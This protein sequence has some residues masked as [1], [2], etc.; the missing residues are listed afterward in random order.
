MS[1]RGYRTQRR[2][3]EMVFLHME[4]KDSHDW[5]TIANMMGT[6]HVGIKKGVEEFE[7]AWWSE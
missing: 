5:V 7:E 3:K 1:F 2:E 6:W 4:V